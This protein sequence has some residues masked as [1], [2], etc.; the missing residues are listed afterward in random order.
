MLAFGLGWMSSHG[1]GGITGASWSA[2]D[3]LASSA[4]DVGEFV[5]QATMAY[6]V[7]ASEVRHPVEVAAAQQEHL[8]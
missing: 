6:T 5:R 8:G 3:S 4:N 2:S 1:L 7:Y